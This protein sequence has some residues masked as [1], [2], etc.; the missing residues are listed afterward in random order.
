[1][2]GIP[3]DSR[4][5]KGKTWIAN[6]LNEARLEQLRALNQIASNRE[7]SLSQMALAWVLRD[8]VV[9]TVLMGASKV[10]QVEENLGALKNLEF[11]VKERNEIEEIL[12]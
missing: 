7:Q 5:G 2:N 4:I 11:S 9:T 6:E 1:M 3:E 10:S 12:K 8:E